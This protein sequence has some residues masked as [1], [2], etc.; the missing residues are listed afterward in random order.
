MKELKLTHVELFSVFHF[1]SVAANVSELFCVAH[2]ANIERSLYHSS[3]SFKYQ[4]L[5]TYI[6]ASLS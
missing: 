3:L 5:D 4:I 2:L 1:K 6:L